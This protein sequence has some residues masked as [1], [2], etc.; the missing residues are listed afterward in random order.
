MQR[1]IKNKSDDD[2]GD[3][4]FA[5]EIKIRAPLFLTF[6]LIREKTLF[7]WTIEVAERTLCWTIDYR[8]FTVEQ[9]EIIFAFIPIA[10]KESPKSIMIAMNCKCYA[11]KCILFLWLLLP[12]VTYLWVRVRALLLAHSFFVSSYSVNSL[13][14]SVQEMCMRVIGFT[15]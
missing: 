4:T 12:I 11:S 7:F 8:L 2:D 1:E 10:M 5:Q 9:V 6:I 3:N 13:A 15:F 14:C